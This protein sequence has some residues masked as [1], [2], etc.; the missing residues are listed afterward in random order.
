MS[1]G[2]EDAS[3]FAFYL[4]RG[5]F[6]IFVWGPLVVVPGR[7][8]QKLLPW[9]DTKAKMAL[10]F[11]PVVLI[12]AMVLV[13]YYLDQNG[14]RF[15]L[16]GPLFIWNT[17][18]N[19]TS[20]IFGYYNFFITWVCW[21]VFVVFISGVVLAPVH[22]GF[23]FGLSRY[24]AQ[25][26]DSHGSAAWGDN[27]AHTR[28]LPKGHVGSLALGR[29]CKAG[30][31]FDPRYRVD[32][33]ILTCAPTGAGKGIGCVIPNLLQY[34]GSVFVLD[35]KGENAAVTAAYREQL[36]SCHIIDPFGVVQGRKSCSVNWLDSIDIFSQSCVGKAASLA[37]TLVVRDRD[38][39]SHWDESASSLIQG[40][41]LYAASQPDERRHPGFLRELLTL[42]EAEFLAILEEVAQDTNLA[43]GIPARTANAFLAK[44][45]R[46]R[47]G[48]LSTAQR[49]TAFLDDPRIVETLKK[50]DVDF[51]TIKTDIVSVYLVLP[52]DKLSSYQRYAKAIIQLAIKAQMKPGKPDWATV[53]FLD[54]FA[55]LGHF[56]AV[57]DGISIVRGYGAWFWLFVQDLSQLQAVYPKWRTF[58]ANAVLQAF[59]SADQM[60]E[61]RAAQAP[62]FR[63]GD[64]GVLP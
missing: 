21:F 40:I 58:L 45:S 29:V 27:I 64:S 3:D 54:E 18:P 2:A 41:L 19:M 5:L 30:R 26:L 17:I 8:W 34:P 42:P 61:L 31:R 28:L 15:D 7:L 12:A 63:H 44:A 37:D 57:E 48:V 35:L 23:L 55:Q 10:A 24:Y 20:G 33:H 1:K 46:E 25:N 22:L 16:L 56:K 59:G 62:G 52:P 38:A 4:L 36:G 13:Q 49:H 32:G 39:D 11:V 51:A 50:S 47:S 6:W 53:F 60:T 9:F 14:I 43:F